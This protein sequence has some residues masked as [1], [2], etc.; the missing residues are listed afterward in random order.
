MEF[1]TDRSTFTE[2]VAQ[3]ARALPARSPVPVLGGLLLT[4]DGSTLRVCGLG[5]ETSSWTDVPVDTVRPGQAL[6][7]GRRLLDICRVLPAGPVECAIE[8]SRFTVAGAGARFGL[9]LL[10]LDD[11]PPLPVLPERR[12]TVDEGDFADAVAHVAVAAGR[13]DALPVLTGIRMCLEGDTM[14]LAATDR[15]RFAVR[16]LGW[17]AESG[18]APADVVIPAR[19]LADVARSLG[20]TGTVGVALGNGSVGFGT[21]R[22]R[23]TV[24]LL[25]G[26]LPG[27]EKLFTMEGQAVAVTDRASLL[28]AVGRVAVVA[29][30]GSPVR[31]DFSSGAVH[32]HAG[33]ADDVASQ[34]LPARLD[35]AEA[36]TVAFNPA[37][38]KDAL[39]AISGLSVR[40]DLLG[41][42]RRALLTGLTAPDAEPDPAH[43]HL[44]MSLKPLV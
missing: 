30:G 11:H 37:Y 20:R 12:G 31:L 16:S 6:V 18:A 2:T 28:E 7:A 19:R 8:G 40:F 32:L 9:S 44:L 38:L 33:Y 41:P 26:R 14:T 24:R 42:G 21:A 34:R 5:D 43:R 22:T 10:P 23:T 1:R 3:V 39:S 35:H 25:D 36:V 4:A 29:E 15:Y 17:E 13:D 27:H